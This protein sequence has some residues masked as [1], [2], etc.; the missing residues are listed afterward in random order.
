M[1]I[2]GAKGFAKEVLEVLHQLNQLEDIAFYDDVNQDIGDYLYRKFSIL[3]SEEAVK[4]FFLKF[5]YHFSI[6]IGNPT[7][8]YKLYQKFQNLGGVFVS[9]ISPLAQIGSYDVRIGAGCNILGNAVF[10]N[11]VIIGKGCIVYYNV[12]ITHDCIVGDFV[13]L[14]PSVTLLGN[15]EIGDFTQIGSN[16]TILP[17][18]KIGKNVI[19]GAGSVVTKDI[20]DNCLAVGS[21]AKVIRNIDPINY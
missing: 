9:V 11:S 20:E 21:P 10:S 15:V 18:V 1:L 6:G 14:S 2:V 7:L 5:G 17:K 4:A 8:R 3:K 13:E 16:S 19:I 12:L